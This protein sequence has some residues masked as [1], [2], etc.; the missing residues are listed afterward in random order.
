MSDRSFL[1]TNVLVYALDEAEPQKRDTARRL[2][3]SKDYGEFVL[4][5]QILSEFY[6]VATRKL[7][8]PVAE[9]VAA[10]AIDQLSQLPIVSID[11]A[12]VKDAIELSRSA[13]VSYWDGLILAAAT[14]GGCR[15]LLTEDLNDGQTIGSIQVENPFLASR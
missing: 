3:G 9:D 12:L 6:V 15:R 11:P 10:A 14:R 1:D 8:Q 13:Q 5:A 2:L 7:T 4:S